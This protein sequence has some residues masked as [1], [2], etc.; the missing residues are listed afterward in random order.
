MSESHW[1]CPIPSSDP[2]PFLVPS[3]SAGTTSTSHLGT[4][5]P[6][7]KARLG[8]KPGIPEESSY[9]DFHHSNPSP[10]KPRLFRAKLTNPATEFRA[11]N[12]K[13]KNNLVFT[14]KHLYFSGETEA[15]WILDLILGVCSTDGV[16][17]IPKGLA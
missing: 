3:A 16:F 7:M 10:K 12:P 11:G 8:W 13:E 9:N 6:P 17:F 15:G 5:K 1:H 2:N 4:I 14:K